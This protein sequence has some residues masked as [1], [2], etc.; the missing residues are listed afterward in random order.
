V[1]VLQGGEARDEEEQEAE[2]EGEGDEEGAGL[3][4]FDLVNRGEGEEDDRPFWMQEG[5]RISSPSTTWG[6][7]SFPEA[8]STSREASGNEPGARGEV[9]WLRGKPGTGLQS[10]PGP[11]RGTQ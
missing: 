7:G 8:S 4:G 11:H 5:G 1:Q 9:P 10:L 3:S 6:R 2:E